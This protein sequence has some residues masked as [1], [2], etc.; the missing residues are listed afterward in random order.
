MV[1]SRGIR[2]QD[3]ELVERIKEVKAEHPN[4]GY[5]RVHSLL[6]R[7]VGYP[8]NHKR[9]HRL[10]KE[11]NLT[12]P[13]NKRLKAKRSSHRDK[14]RTEECNAIWGT[15]MTKISIQGFGWAYLHVVLDWGSKKAV[16][17]QLSTRSKTSDWLEAVEMAVN[18]Q[19]P[20]GILNK[21]KELQ[22]VSDNG[23]QPTSKF[24]GKRCKEYDIKQIFTSFGNPKGNADT[25]RF[26]RTIKED[27]VW[28]WEYT[29]FD[30]LKQALDRWMH[31]YNH[32]WPHSKHKM[33]PCEYEEEM[34][35]G[36]DI[37]LTDILEDT[38]PF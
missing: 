6:S 20:E 1:K 7:K 30:A 27:L 29:S 37:D 28:P 16:G 4:W 21:E 13:K 19:F 32:E 9:V 24:F 14:P 23:C 31:N 12:V 38:L 2:P 35:R 8:L 33:T 15:D 3:E 26:I 10:M 5:R 25:E 34:S 22:L 11:L 18:Q 36:Y 17:W